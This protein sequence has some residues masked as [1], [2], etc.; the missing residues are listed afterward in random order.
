MKKITIMTLLIT[1]LVACSEPPPIVPH[2]VIILH[3]DTDTPIKV[4]A[5]DLQTD[6]NK[7]LTAEISLVNSNETL[8]QADYYFFV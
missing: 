1:L 3:A 6:I 5:K 7:V 2:I 4:A 8:P